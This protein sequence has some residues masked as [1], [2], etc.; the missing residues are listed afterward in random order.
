MLSAKWKKKR[1]WTLGVSGGLS[2]SREAKGG[3]TEKQHFNKD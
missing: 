2:L 3:L 1:S